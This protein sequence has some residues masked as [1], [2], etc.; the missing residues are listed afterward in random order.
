MLEKLGLNTD[1]MF[2]CMFGLIFVL[3]VLVF[4]LLNKVTRLTNIYVK[5]MRGANGKSLEESFKEK[6]EKLDK[7]LENEETLKNRISAMEAVKEA[8]FCKF[9][10][11]KYDAFD[12]IGG[13]LSFSLCLLTE[14]NDGIVLSAMHSTSGCY[15]YLKEIIKG[16][17]F[18]KLSEQETRVLSDA[19]AYNDPVSEF[20]KD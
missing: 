6:F 2:I 16:K 1:I 15:T 19:I 3:L 18:N 8:G 9:A 20:I 4:I 11:R 5:Y 10:V 12:E 17:A 7:V 13:K 14:T